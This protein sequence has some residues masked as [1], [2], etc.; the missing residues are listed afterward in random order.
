MVMPAE[1]CPQDPWFKTLGAF[2]FPTTDKSCCIV[3]K[4][5]GARCYSKDQLL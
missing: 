1:Y 5:Q 3:F 4:K 2:I